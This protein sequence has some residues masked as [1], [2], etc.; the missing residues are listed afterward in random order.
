MPDF[1]L[2]Y[3]LYSDSALAFC[4]IT[5]IYL[6]VIS[7]FYPKI[8]RPTIR[9]NSFIGIIFGLINIMNVFI[10]LLNYWWITILHIPLL[11]ISVYMFILSIKKEK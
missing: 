3:L 1:N 4:M 10:S 8:N 7:L 5:P 9:V 6:A 2:S 11:S